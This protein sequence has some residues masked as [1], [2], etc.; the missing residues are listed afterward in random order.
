MTGFDGLSCILPA[1][2]EAPRIGAVLTAV[3]AQ[4]DVAEVIVVDDGSQ[5][6][7]AEVAERHRDRVPGLRVLRMP[8]NGGKTRAV[9][10]G[11]AEATR[12]HLMLVDTDLTGLGGA[13]L[14][15]LV[16]PVADG[17]AGASL[18]LRANAPWPWRALGIDYISGERVLPR[19]LLADRLDALDAL[20]RFGLEVFMNELWL[21]AGWPVAVVP[22]PGGA[23]P[24]KAEKAGG[25]RAGLR[26]DAAMMADIFRTVGVTATA[27]QIF[28][29]RARRL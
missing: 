27:R 25:W 20:P 22:W 8:R 13:H 23:S 4:R 9:A 16:A 12:S 15:A 5:D 2:N 29:L 1:F 21:E 6:G 17:R 11:I 26:A 7:T 28:A 10:A 24:L 19:A 3:A 18:S 14:D